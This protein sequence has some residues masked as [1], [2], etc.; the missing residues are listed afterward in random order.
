MNIG[1]PP[2]QVEKAAL[3]IHPDWHWSGFT[4][5]DLP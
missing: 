5:W 3:A 2:D 4:K 1:M